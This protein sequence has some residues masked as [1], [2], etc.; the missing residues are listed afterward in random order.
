MGRHDAQGTLSTDE[1]L[2][3]CL[4]AIGID[5]QPLGSTAVT[6]Q[7]RPGALILAAGPEKGAVTAVIVNPDCAPGNTDIRAQRDI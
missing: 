2:R 6:Y 3:A 7:G 4:T 1:G 5:R